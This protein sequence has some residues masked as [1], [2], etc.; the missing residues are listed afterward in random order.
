MC[1][2]RCADTVHVSAWYKCPGGRFVTYV[3]VCPGSLGSQRDGSH[4]IV[5]Y[6]IRARQAKMVMGLETLQ[7]ELWEHVFEWCGVDQPD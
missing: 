2:T 1:I 7:T 3:K 6:S 4:R 5:F